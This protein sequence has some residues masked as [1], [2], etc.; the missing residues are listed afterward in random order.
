MLP[1]ADSELVAIIKGCRNNNRSMQNALY[2]KFY[3]YGMSVCIR[4]VHAEQDAVAVL[5]EAFLR[6]F[7][8]I[9]AFNLEQPFIPWFR[10]I[11]INTSLDQLRNQK[12]FKEETELD[13]VVY[14]IPDRADVLSRLAYADLLEMVQTLM[15][16]YRT[17]FNLYAIDGYK[18]EEI[19]EILGIS[20]SA[21]KTNLARARIK[22]QK[23][24]TN[25]LGNDA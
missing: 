6:V 14:E 4:Y 24:L 16:P 12:R 20:L 9:Q 2:R 7:K 10:K 25:K 3:A 22:L 15:P 13:E 8:N 17:V 23:L 19:A 18:H 11:L 1:E 5:N 21:S